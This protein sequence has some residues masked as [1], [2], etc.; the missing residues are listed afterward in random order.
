MATGSMTDLAGGPHAIGFL[1]VPAFSMIAFTSSIEPLRLA[2]R[3]SGKQLFS[4]KLYSPDGQPIAASNGVRIAVDG[5][6][7][8]VEVLPEIIVCSG[9]DVEKY[10]HRLLVAK[11]RR[12]ASHGISI[13]AVCTGTFVLAQAGL[14][15][16]YRCTIHWENH[17][18][19]V[20]MFPEIDV[21]QELF[22]F[23]RNRFSCAGG[24]AAIDMMLSFI[25]ARVSKEIAALVSDELI[26]HRIRDAGEH[27]RME[28]RKRL[29]VANPKLLTV[30]AIMESNLETPLSCAQIARRMGMSKRQLERLFGRYLAETPIRYY[31]SLRLQRA[32]QLLQQTTMPVLSVALACGFVSA[33][34]FSKCY[35]DHFGRTPSAERLGKPS[36][37]PK[38]PSARPALSTT[39]GGA[40]GSMRRVGH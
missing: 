27:Q 36:E 17:D 26:H 28:L 29:G 18:S 13:G 23:D 1:L 8:D 31:L 9:V 21:T 6:Y 19:F 10:D 24:T 35:S 33:S 22:E 40:N 38:G 25:S 7:A 14:L 4:W 39:R 34:H 11:L 5:A 2:N 16:G 15:D 32:K 30:V 12:L 37:P 20:E 3:V